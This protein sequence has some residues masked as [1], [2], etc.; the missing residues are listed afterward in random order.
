MYST[1]IMLSYCIS[2]RDR[3]SFVSVALVQLVE[4]SP[5]EKDLEGLSRFRRNLF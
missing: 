4:T 5:Q 2:A 1:C 3:V